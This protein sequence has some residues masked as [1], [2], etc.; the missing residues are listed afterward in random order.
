LAGFQVLLWRYTGQEEVAV[1]TPIA[2][3]KWKDVEG[4]IG[5]FVNTLVL[6]TDL[7]GAPTFR[8]LL[9]R[10]R[11]VCLRAY[12][13]QDVPFERVVA[14]L[15]PRRE[16]GATPLFQVMF[17]L[18]N[19]PTAS[20]QLPGL[21]ISPF[22]IEVE[23][24]VFDMSLVMSEVGDEIS[25]GLTYNSELFEAEM[26]E[27][28]AGHLQTLL[29]GI[30]ADPQQRISELPLLSERERRQIL[31][32]WNDTAVPYPRE[33]CI[34]ELF[35]A[36]AAARPE[37]PAVVCGDKR[38]SYGELDA[39]AN[40]LAH[41][42]RGLG[43]GPETRVGILLERGFE[44]I[45][46]VFGVLKA[47]GA[48]VPMDMTYPKQR[49]AFMLEDARPLALITQEHL[50]EGLDLQGVKLVCMDALRQRVAA[51]S[52]RTPPSRVSP[53]NVAYVIYTSG[54]TGKPKGILLGHEGLC[55]EIV[56]SNRLFNV[57]ADSRVLQ[58]AAFGFDVAVW[59]IC[60]ALAAGATLVLRDPGAAFPG[61]E[62]L[63][64]MREQ[65][66][67]VALLPPSL[68]SL[69]DGDDLPALRTVVAVGEK[70]SAEAA[71]RWSAPG[72]SFFNGYGPAECTVTVSVHLVGD[73]GRQP[74][75]PPIGRPMANVQLYILDP[76]MQPLPVGVPGE[77]YVGGVQ[78]ARGYLNRPGLTAEKFVPDPFGGGAGARLYRT[79]DVARYLP[80][81]DIEFV[82][83]K[84]D[85]VK[86]RGHRIELGEIEAALNEFPGVLESI[87]LAR[88][89]E[90]GSKTL[91]AY[92]VGGPEL[93][94]RVREMRQ[95]LK[96]KLPDYMT[97]AAVVPLE[98]WPRTSN[99]K[100]D[101]GALPA[102][103]NLRANTGAVFQPARDYVELKLQS[104]WEEVLNF[105]PIGIRDNFFDL[106]GHSMLALRLLMQV[107]K[108]FD[109]NLPLSTLLSTPTIETLA[110]ALRQNTWAERWPSL[111]NITPGD[112]RPP[113]FF[114]HSVGGN[115][116]SYVELARQLGPDQPFYA[117]QSRGLDG[118]QA[119]LTRVEEMAAHYIAEMRAARPAGPYFLGGWSMGGIVAFEMARQLSARGEEVALLALLDSTTSVVNKPG[120][121]ADETAFLY[122]FVRDLLLSA[123]QTNWALPEQYS[124]LRPDEQ[125]AA[126][127]DSERSL[128]ILPAGLEL[129]ELRHLLRVFREN[130]QAMWRYEPRPY[131]GRITLFR[132][133][134]RLE[135]G[136]PEAHLG[137]GELALA[138]I[139]E[140]VVPGN[141]YTILR[142]PG[143]GAIT[144]VLKELVSE[145]SLV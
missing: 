5:F 46:S 79:G 59:E 69:L 28:M 120:A 144:A 137:W 20:V 91:V 72:R 88:E 36:R 27:R 64:Q 128:G 52:S 12:E 106:G 122:T 126:F 96:A 86:I 140:H 61:P 80:D 94:S 124:R 116:M 130:V 47:G 58:F 108:A 17:A 97:P 19:A 18:Q 115:V 9:G 99:G 48:Y 73:A 40:Q 117:L 60:M 125:L 23:K 145:R 103:D 62:L 45:V 123:G 90:P 67:S 41:Y 42:L 84:D 4:L 136:T 98:A 81:G 31:V 8:E 29:K 110:G 37:A 57:T 56:E 6:R 15:A 121:E 55:N 78:V 87:V 7:S 13:H 111:V 26:I 105:R 127:L 134:E 131:A 66:V 83:R 11:E 138:G 71:A 102:P 51:E 100:V 2:N 35:E 63:A 53:Q 92:V 39:R 114:V 93:A 139:D 50:V 135:G 82:G 32:E 49:L 133:S 112:A 43:V 10:V 89:D 75:G 34:H 38:L 1:G 113:I 44:M 24:S 141:H 119:P 118:A 74:Q 22:V 143:V 101:R 109:R 25:V 54:S 70:C 14:E 3:R 107:Q 30:V 16:A 129:K 65:E 77:L 21:T 33:T 85:Q 76:Q 132:A 142:A 95:S 68:M 104:I